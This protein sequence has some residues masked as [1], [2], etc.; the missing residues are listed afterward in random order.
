MEECQNWKQVVHET[1]EPIVAPPLSANQEPI[2]LIGIIPWVDKT[3]RIWAMVVTPNQVSPHFRCIATM[4]LAAWS[5]QPQYFLKH[6]QDKLAS[7]GPYRPGNDGHTDRLALLDEAIDNVISLINLNHG[8]AFAFFAY[9]KPGGGEWVVKGL[10]EHQ[11]CTDDENFNF[12]YQ[13]LI[14][15]NMQPM[16]ISDNEADSNEEI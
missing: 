9:E 7:L 8:D 16:A 14:N 13:A 11:K 12:I 15:K 1:I 6:L 10:D 3:Y 4:M 2:P 5:Q